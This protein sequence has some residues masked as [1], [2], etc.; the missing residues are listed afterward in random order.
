MPEIET[1]SLEEGCRKSRLGVWSKGAG[2]R[3]LKSEVKVPEIETWS[4]E[5]KLG[6][7]QARLGV[8]SPDSTG[9]PGLEF[10]VITVPESQAWSLEA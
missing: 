4:L 6:A 3:D 9:K 5:E 1:W 10:G 2:N 8:W 7:R